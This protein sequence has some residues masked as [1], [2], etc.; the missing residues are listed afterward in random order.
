LNKCF[1]I[2]D[3]VQAVESIFLSFD[4]NKLN[5]DEVVKI[6]DCNNLIERKICEYGCNVA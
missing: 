3:D 6:C 1:I 4:W 2:D 5:I